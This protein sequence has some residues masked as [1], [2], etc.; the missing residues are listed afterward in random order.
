M[1]QHFAPV[2]TLAAVICIA[3]AG[4]CKT[5]NDPRFLDQW[6]MRA[7]GMP[8]AWQ[9]LEDGEKLHSP[10]GP[11]VVAVLDTGV[12]LNHPDFDQRMLPGYDFVSHPEDRDGQ[13]GRD[14]DPTDPGPSFHGT[15]VAGII[16]AG[17][18]NSIGIAGVDG[19]CRILP[20]RVLGTAGG[21][22]LE[23]DVADAIRWAIGKEVTGVL[24]NT[25]PA[26]V[27]NLS[28][29]S[30]EP[31]LV[32]EA[33]I[34]EALA[35]GVIVVAAAGNAGDKG[36]AAGSFYPAAVPGVIAV[37][38]AD[39]QGHRAPYSDLGSHVLLLAPGGTAAAPEEGIVST[40]Y[41]IGGQGQA[42]PTY[43]TE[44]GT[45]QAAPHVSGAAALVRS[46]APTVRQRTLAALLRSSSDSTK[47]C[48]RDPTGGCGAGLLQVDKLLEWAKTQANCTCGGDTYCLGS[49]CVD[50]GPV[51]AE[52]FA[53]LQAGCAVTSGRD[54]SSNTFLGVSA[55]GLILLLLRR[56]RR[57]LFPKMYLYS[58]WIDAGRAWR[59]I[60]HHSRCMRVNKILLS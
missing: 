20:L 1:L 46:I 17:T 42:G 41:S 14:E 5:P 3:N 48:D 47:R 28:F 2:V 11:V 33:A 40:Y 50:P 9:M 7:I 35:E 38:A 34:A 13:P 43:F 23:S 58:K 18:D 52:I 25:T 27:L 26:S 37:G 55:I 57:C 24:R 32:I 45:S 53:P 29:G 59:G 4:Y 36:L 31:S 44:I 16:G 56:P 10:R 39:N 21:R 8:Q 54:A 60:G 19:N 15:H 51:S 49:A 22:V 6:D 12:V 30:E